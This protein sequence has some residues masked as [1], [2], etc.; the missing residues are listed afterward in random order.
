MVEVLLLDDLDCHLAARFLVPSSDYLRVT[1]PA[2]VP[3]YSPM[4]Y[5]SSS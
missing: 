4:V 2:L 5:D 3:E 1:S